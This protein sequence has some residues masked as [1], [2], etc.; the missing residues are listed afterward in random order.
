MTGEVVYVPN[1]TIYVESVENLSRRRFYSY[2]YLVPFAKSS[3]AK[4]VST[5]LKIIEGKISSYYPIEI[6]YKSENPNA[7]DYMYR[8]NVKF[9]EE[10]KSL[11]IEMQRFLVTYIF[12][13]N[14]S[15]NTESASN[16]K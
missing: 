8:I 13:G 12:S 2:E 11:D 9:P 14:S 4:E 6:S 15:K 10:N 5:A 1:N 3:S 16:I 7:T